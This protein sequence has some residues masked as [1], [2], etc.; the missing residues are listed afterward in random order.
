MKRVEGNIA[1]PKGF[2]A[3][4][5]HS[6]LKRKKMDLGWIYSEVPASVAGVFTTNQIQ[7][8]PLKIT[9]EVVLGEKI[10]G[11][12]VNSGN[13][14]ACT[15]EQ[16]LANAQ[17]MQ[18]HVADIW[19]V[20]KELVAVASTGIIGKQLPMPTIE[21][22]IKTLQKSS[23]IDPSYFHKAI[24]T[25]DTVEKVITVETEIEEKTITISACGKGSGMIHPNMATMLGFITTDAAITSSIL[26]KCLS[27]LT[28]IT[29]NQITV[30]GDTSTNDMV[31]VMA[32]GLADNPEI[33]EEGSNYQQFK[34]AFHFVL[35]ELA[36]MIARDGEGAT[37]LIEV[38]VIQARNALEARMIAKSIVGSM[39]V[40]SA[41]FGKDPNWG[42]ILCAVGYSGVP[43]DSGTIK[44]QLADTLVFDGEP[45]AFDHEKIVKELEDPEIKIIVSLGLGNE[46]GQAWGCDLTYDYVKINALYHT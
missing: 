20:E 45:I 25:T 22:G 2:F 13:A 44:I 10:K 36:K 18:K 7:A 38:D 15:G 6:G 35:T 30:D 4:G 1:S 42:R 33:V 40:K 14:N 21:E 5:I 17:E 46:M 9:K 19:E 32:N 11:V 12:I 3:N 26:Q 27:E 31:L 29:F 37:K 41:I 24:L 8:A 39:L 23:D 16:G 43:F 34:A 28:E